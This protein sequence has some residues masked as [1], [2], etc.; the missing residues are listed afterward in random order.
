[1]S[2]LARLLLPLVLVVGV[3]SLLGPPP[4]T[5]SP[6]RSVDEPVA[7]ASVSAG[8]NHSCVV[9][10]EQAVRCWGDGDD[11]RLGYGNT[12]RVGDGSVLGAE[13]AAAAGDASAGAPASPM[14]FSVY[15]CMLVS[16]QTVCVSMWVERAWDAGSSRRQLT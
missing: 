5:A 3:L 9:T 10:V 6:T 8:Y 16:P 12:A 14:G 4:A 13:T 7:A 1:M 2:R 11:G 15:S